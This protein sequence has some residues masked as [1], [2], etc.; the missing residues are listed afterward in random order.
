MNTLARSN[1][2]TYKAVKSDF[3][4]HT[5]LINF[6]TTMAQTVQ[7]QVEKAIEAL[8]SRNEGLAGAVAINEPRVNALEEVID[9]HAVKTIVG[10]SLPQEDVRLIVATIK[11]NNDL[12]RMGDLAVNIAQRVIS[13]SA[14]E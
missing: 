9:E 14:D 6:L 4:N 13:L 7:G 8:L 10:R 1:V 5:T 3:E 2:R 11:I 12:E